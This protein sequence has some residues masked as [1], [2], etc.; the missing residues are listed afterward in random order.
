MVQEVPC[1]FLSE[2]LGFILSSG[3]EDSAGS[4]N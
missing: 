2:Q 3:M 1:Y 4:D